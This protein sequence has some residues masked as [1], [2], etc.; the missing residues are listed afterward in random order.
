M[1]FIFGSILDVIVDVLVQAFLGPILAPKLPRRPSYIEWF[2]CRL[3][4][5]FY[6]TCYYFGALLGQMAQ[7]LLKPKEISGSGPK[8]VIS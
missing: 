5:C 3:F 8:Q 6:A 7:T 1:G 4:C 2:P